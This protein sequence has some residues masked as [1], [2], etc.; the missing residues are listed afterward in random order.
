MSTSLARRDLQMYIGIDHTHD[1]SQRSWLESANG[2]LDFPL[3][4]LPLCR[5]VAGVSEIPK[6]GIGIGDRI[7]NA[8]ALARVGGLPSAAQAA[9]QYVASG[10]LA[11]LMA[12][13]P[14]A[15]RA[16]RHAAFALLS[17]GVNPDHRLLVE[18]CL[19]PQKE[20]RLL[21]P[22]RPLNFSDFYTSIHHAKRIGALVRPD[23]PLLPNYRWLPVAYTGR[24]SSI[25]PS[26]QAFV[27]PMGQ[28]PTPSGVP[29][30]VACRRLDY[31]AELGILVGSPTHLGDRVSLD[32]APG[33]IFGVCL[34]NDWSARDIQFWEYAPMGPFLGKSFASHLGGWVVTSEALAPFRGPTPWSDDADRQ[35]LPHLDSPEDRQ[36]GALDITVDVFIS[37]EAMRAQGLAPH[38][39]SSSNYRDSF[40]TAAQLLAHQSSNGANLETGDVLGTGTLSGPGDDS[41]ACLME[42]T[43]G[44][45][46]AFT[47]PTGEKR[48]FVEDGD[49]ITMTGRCE[50]PGFARIGLGEVRARVLP[51]NLPAPR[52]CFP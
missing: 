37:S 27:R 12:A 49:E 19:V 39:L 41:R 11:P 24:T 36:R 45:K 16:M 28:T 13:G 3:T 2:H 23:A 48:L 51:A 40:W 6:V 7:L 25:I 43:N 32:D 38:K 14:E 9:F 46:Q 20:A 5:F 18:Q 47:L 10:E 4:N 42:L 35:V 52:Y 31:E 29:E 34:L 26:G 30:F 8:T 21:L 15:S 17:E 50:K 22:C 33:H 44:G 1:S